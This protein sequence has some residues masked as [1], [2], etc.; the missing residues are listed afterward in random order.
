MARLPYLVMDL[1]VLLE[2]CLTIPLFSKLSEPFGHRFELSNFFFRKAVNIFF[3]GMK[4]KN[5]DNLIQISHF[6]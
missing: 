4:V 1:Q 3:H 2:I 5:P 6:G